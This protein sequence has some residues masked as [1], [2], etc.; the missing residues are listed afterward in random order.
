MARTAFDRPAEQ[1]V[2]EYV[3]TRGA[4]S[5]PIYTSHALRALRTVM[6][7][8]GL[9][10]RELTDLVAAAAIRSGRDVAFDGAV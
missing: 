1:I 5:I 7:G 10:D 2:V 9:T 6:P 8:C 4:S 3:E